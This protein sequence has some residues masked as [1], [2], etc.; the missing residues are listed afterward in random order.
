MAAVLGG[1]V[2]VIGAE[3]S[4]SAVPRCP[5]MLPGSWRFWKRA[6]L[7]GVRGAVTCGEVG[8]GDKIGEDTG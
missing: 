5:C 7:R 4:G 8:M 2:T 1:V 3:A 6:W